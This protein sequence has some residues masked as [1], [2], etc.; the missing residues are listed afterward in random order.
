MEKIPLTAL[1]RNMGTVW[2]NPDIFQFLAGIKK[3]QKA[4]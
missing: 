1:V 4:E 2:K 3:L